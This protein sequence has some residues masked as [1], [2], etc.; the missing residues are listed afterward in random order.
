MANEVCHIQFDI[1]EDLV[2]KQGLLR[3]YFINTSLIIIGVC[4]LS[5]KFVNCDFKCAPRDES[6]H[7]ANSSRC[8]DLLPVPFK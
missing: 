2:F 1:V 5:V 7:G 4:F 6:D 3:R 8:E